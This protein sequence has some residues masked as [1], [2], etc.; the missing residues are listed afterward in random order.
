MPS[1][2]L[3]EFSAQGFR[4]PGNN[5][6]LHKAGTLVAARIRTRVGTRRVNGT[7]CCNARSRR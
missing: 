5:F 6:I 1:A 4:L 7:R 3:Q 2:L